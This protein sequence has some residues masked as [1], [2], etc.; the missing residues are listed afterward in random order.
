VAEFYSIVYQCL[1]QGSLLACDAYFL[2]GDKKEKANFSQFFLTF[3]MR[4]E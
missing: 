2:A 3:E 1:I 4:T